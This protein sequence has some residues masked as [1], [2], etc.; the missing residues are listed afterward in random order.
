[1]NP[2][3]LILVGVPGA[4]KSTFAKVMADLLSEKNIPSVIISPDSFR[5]M[6]KQKEFDPSSEEF[7]SNA[8]RTSVELALKHGFFV[9]CDDLNYYESMRRK[10][11]DIAVRLGFEYGIVYIS[12]SPETAKEWNRAR[13]NPIPD[14]L[15]DDIYF[16]LDIPGK[17][18]R[19]D[20]PIFSVDLGETKPDEAVIDLVE[21]INKKIKKS[22]LQKRKPRKDSCESRKVRE[23]ERVTR[24]AM[25]TLM[26][27]YRLGD[28]A[29]Q[30]SMLRK[31]IVKQALMRKWPPEKAAS[32]FLE[33][34][35][36]IIKGFQ[37]QPEGKIHIHLGL[38]G[39]IDHGKTSIARCLTE[40]ASTASLD[41]HPESQKRGMTIDMGF[42][43]FEAGK[44]IV[45]LVDLPG[46]HSLMSHVVGGASIID[47]ALLVVDV[48]DGINVQTVEHFAVIR[49][50]G[51]KLIIILNKVDAASDDRINEVEEKIKK[52]LDGYS[53]RIVRVSAFTGQGID[54]LKD[55]ISDEIPPP[56]RIIIGSLKI[57]LDHAFHI[58]GAGTVVTGTIMRGEVKR[59]DTLYLFPIKREVKV[60][61]I[62]I[63]KQNVNRAKA[64]DRVALALSGVK[65][66]EIDRGFILTSSFL[67]EVNFVRVAVKKERFYSHPIRV[68]EV[69]HAGIGLNSTMVEVYP[70]IDEMGTLVLSEAGDEFDAL[71]RL[72]K[73]LVVEEGDMVMLYRGDLSPREMRVVGVGKVTEIFGKAPKIYRKKTRI[74]EFVD[75][76][77]GVM[78]KIRLEKE[79]HLD[80]ILVDGTLMDV[81]SFTDKGVILE[82]VHPGEK[83]LTFF[84]RVKIE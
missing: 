40:T 14:D 72:E 47:G 48:L 78:A 61:G 21:I 20:K 39:H 5:E 2:Y 77:H 52:M 67:S 56:T 45:T 53:A 51:L 10:L 50:L 26:R 49:G 6:I 37:I 80:K 1:M 29:S 54:E 30:I 83:P 58:P 11:K 60:R 75:T 36:N 43:A 16:K 76:R 79:K 71:L 74:C 68:G 4:G 22:D 82:K 84:R 65:P 81:K 3:L 7:V 8:V 63:F 25:G 73:K 12:T 31:E 70:V 41:R 27:E 64:G 44:Y 23:I 17:K 19:W 15:I 9:I 32:E 35:R 18:Y 59:G 46:H 24:H 55:I 13:G 69:M 42:S 38:F 34:A 62:Q 66:D 28:A 57:P 33:N